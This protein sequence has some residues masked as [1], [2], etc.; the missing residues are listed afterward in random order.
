MVMDDRDRHG[1][2]PFIR[3]MLASVEKSGE[4][5]QRKMER[6][7]TVWPWDWFYYRSVIKEG[8]WAREQLDMLKA[9]G[10]DRA[11]E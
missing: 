1:A 4:N 9:R 3:G 11:A 6:W 7:W 10:K 8:K 5:A 2:G